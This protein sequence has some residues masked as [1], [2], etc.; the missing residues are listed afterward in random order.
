MGIYL[1]CGKGKNMEIEDIV[2]GGVDI[3][4]VKKKHPSKVVIKVYDMDAD[5]IE[6]MRGV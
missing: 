4:V 5:R 6:A 1:I 3:E 2:Y